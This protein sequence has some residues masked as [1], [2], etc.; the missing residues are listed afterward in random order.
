[1]SV[2]TVNVKV[3]AIIAFTVSAETPEEA[4]TLGRT[5]A[6][7]SPF[8]SGIQYVD[9]NLEVVGVEGDWHLD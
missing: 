1:M 3:K 2:Y 4:L 9:G 8:K 5:L 7:K 6:N